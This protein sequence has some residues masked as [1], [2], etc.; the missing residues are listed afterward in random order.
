MII[1]RIVNLNIVLA[2]DKNKTKETEK[3]WNEAISFSRAYS[4]QA[5][6][7]TYS[8]I[9]VRTK[10]RRK[11]Y[12]DKF[13]TVLLLLSGGSEN[14]QVYTKLLRLNNKYNTYDTSI[15]IYNVL[16][17]DFCSTKSTITATA[18]STTTTTATATT[19]SNSNVASFVCIVFDWHLI[20]IVIYIKQNTCKTQPNRGREKAITA[21][22]NAC[23]IPY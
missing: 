4:L 12:I 2:K 5:Q 3:N 20:L 11:N 1:V 17:F 21:Y 19:K 9:Y 23:T 6:L 10:K 8:W 18:R 15:C 16:L 13:Q 7:H 22:L 14:A